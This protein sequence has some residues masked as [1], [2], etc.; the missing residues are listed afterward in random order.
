MQLTLR[1]YATATAAVA[2]AS[3]TVI[4]ANPIAPP[5]PQIRVA[6]PNVQ[7]TATFQELFQN[8]TTSLQTL[9]PELAEDPLPVL[10]QILKNNLNSAQAILAPTVDIVVGGAGYILRLPVTAVEAIQALFAEDGGI[11][12]AIGVLVKPLIPLVGD[13]IEL[14]NAIIP[15]IQQPFQ[16]IANAI[17]TLTLGNLAAVGLSFVSPL[18]AGVVATVDAVQAVVDAS[19][20]DNASFDGF[21]KSLVD[22][23]P[24]VVDGAVNGTA[25]VIDREIDLPAPL[26]DVILHGS[27]GGLLSTGAFNLDIGLREVNV[28]LQTSGPIAAV[29]K[30]L[31]TLADVITP[32]EAATANKNGVHELAVTKFANTGSDTTDNGAAGGGVGLA[33]GTA[34]PAKRMAALA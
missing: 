24:T 19:T 31:H 1:P 25:N 26:P 21:V 22:F 5:L 14:Y 12:A 8:T 2:F 7:S 18:I 13:G 16:N 23:I 29:N 30:Y 20:G 4:V 17:G 27:V 6:A 11:G 10:T 32:P 33:R 28:E 15:A 3:A 9:L 34:Q